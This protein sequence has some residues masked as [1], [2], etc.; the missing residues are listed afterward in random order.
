[1]ARAKLFL[2][3][4]LSQ[5]TGR[6]VAFIEARGAVVGKQ[7]EIIPGSGDFWNVDGVSDTVI[8]E[9]TLKQLRRVH[10]EGFNSL[11]ARI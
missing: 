6:D 9:D 2:Q 4:D 8:T 3:C 10:H 7:V 5:G 1:M 11:K